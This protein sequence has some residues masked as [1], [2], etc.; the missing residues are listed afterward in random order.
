MFGFVVKGLAPVKCIGVEP[1][2]VDHHCFNLL[3]QHDEIIVVIVNVGVFDDKLCAEGRETAGRDEK[4]A[5]LAITVEN[6]IW[7]NFVESRCVRYR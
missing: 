3:R 1:I 6:I 7:N 2:S 5:A 4:I